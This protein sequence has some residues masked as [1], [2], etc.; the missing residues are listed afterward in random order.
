[1]TLQQEQLRALKAQYKAR[2]LELEVLRKEVQEKQKQ[3]PKKPV[4]E[5]T[6]QTLA[7]AREIAT[8]N[9][10]AR[11]KVSINNN[12]KPKLDKKPEDMIL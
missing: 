5:K 4:P 3:V 11:N 7:Y 10:V 2:R 6:L 9:R 8:A 12:I 1:M